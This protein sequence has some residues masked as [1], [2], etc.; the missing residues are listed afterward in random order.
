MATETSLEPGV[1]AHAMRALAEHFDTKGLPAPL[2]VTVTG[3]DLLVQVHADGAE[4]WA[5]SLADG[6]GITCLGSGDVGYLRTGGLLPDS[7]VRV[8]LTWSRGN[9]WALPA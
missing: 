9:S 1:V 7:G 3:R 4:R 8:R 2:S 6:D 5:A